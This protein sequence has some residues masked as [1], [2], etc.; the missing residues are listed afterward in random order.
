MQRRHHDG[1][2]HSAFVAVIPDPAFK[3]RVRMSYCAQRAFLYSWT[4]FA[5]AGCADSNLAAGRMSTSTQSPPSTISFAV[6]GGTLSSFWQHAHRRQSRPL[7]I[8]EVLV[9]DCTF[10]APCALLHTTESRRRLRLLCCVLMTE[11]LWLGL[12]GCFD[13][14]KHEPRRMGSQVEPSRAAVKR[15]LHRCDMYDL[16]ALSFGNTLGGA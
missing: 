4:F 7:G 12:T 2:G 15:H 8:L 9:L 11:L 16:A 1:T 13:G 6:A 14:G 5:P 3:C 10:A